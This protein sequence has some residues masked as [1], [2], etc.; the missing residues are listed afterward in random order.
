M[1]TPL[2]TG[3]FRIEDRPSAIQSTTHVVEWGQS[4]LTQSLLARSVLSRYCSFPEQSYLTESVYKVVLQKSI[5]T[6]IRPLILVISNNEGQS[7]GSVREFTFPQ[8][9]VKKKS[10]G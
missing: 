3:H 8:R 6:Q 1:S 2:K 9:L 7:D 4:W 10:V 5:P